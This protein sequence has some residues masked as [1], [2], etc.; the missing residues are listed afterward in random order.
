LEQP[1]PY[2]LDSCQPGWTCQVAS[3]RWAAGNAGGAHREAGRAGAAAGNDDA[4]DDDHRHA[5][6]GA[7]TMPTSSIMPII[8]VPPIIGAGCAGL[9]L[10][11]PN[12]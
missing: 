12:S 6:Y 9:V 4:D 2:Q 7:T 1:W 3:S 11:E 10:V 8:M 5:D